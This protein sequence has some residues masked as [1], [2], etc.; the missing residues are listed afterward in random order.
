MSSL[1]VSRFAAA[2]ALSLLLAAPLAR[3][4][5]AEPGTSA[6]TPGTPIAAAPQQPQNLIDINPLSLAFGEISVEYEH[7]MSPYATVVIGPKVLAFNGAGAT[8]GV[9]QFGFGADLGVHFFPLGDALHG[10]WLGPQLSLA[11]AHVSYEDASGDGLGIAGYGV[12]GYTFIP[13]D[14][15][16]ISIGLGAGYESA[17]ATAT[18]SD[19]TTASGSQSG[20]ALTGRLAIGYAW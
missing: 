8:S 11:Y 14:H 12:I 6:A 16:A 17:G 4:Q 5:S 13:V 15:L 3:A 10:F 9:S 1:N 7:A 18:G 20:F 19:G 2:A